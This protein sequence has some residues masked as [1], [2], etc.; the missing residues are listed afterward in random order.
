MLRRG[1]TTHYP[2]VHL[3]PSGYQDKRY[4]WVDT[5]SFVVMGSVGKNSAAVPDTSAAAD[6][7]IPLSGKRALLPEWSSKHQV[8]QEEVRA[9][10]TAHPGWRNTGLLTGDC[11][12]L[13]SDIMDP[14]AAE[15]LADTI[16][17]WFDGRG[18]ILTRF[19]EAPKF[20]TLFRTDTPFGKFRVDLVSP[21]GT[22]HHIEVLCDGQQ[23]VVDG[24]HPDTRKPYSWHGD[25]R[26]GTI[27]RSELPD[28]T[29]QELR[30]LVD[31]LVQILQEK[32][33]Y[34]R[35]Q[36]SGGGNG[37][38]PG[39]GSHS[40]VD[41]ERGLA[42]IRYGNI[43]DTWSRVVG[44][45]LRKGTPADTIFHR[46]LAATM[47]AAA[48][49]ADPK[50]DRWMAGLANIFTGYM[51]SD[52]S[53]VGNLSTKAQVRWHEQINNGERPKLAWRPDHGEFGQLY[54]RR[55]KG[56]DRK[57][58]EKQAGVKEE[59]PAGSSPKDGKAKP[60]CRFKL[61][62]FADL[63]LGSDPLYLVDELIPVRGLVDVWG[64]AKCGKSFWA[65]DLS[66]HI[67]MGWEY[68][69][70]YVQQ[71]AVVYCAFEGGHGFKKRKEALR[72]HYN[73]AED[74][75]VPLYL[76]PGQAN[77]I[78]EHAQLIA[79]ISM[80]LGEVR[81]VAVVLDTLNKSLFGSENKDID[82]GAYIRAAEAIRDAYDSVAL[83]I[84]H[85]GHDDTRPRGHSSLPGAVDAQLAV[86]RTENIVTV[87]VEMMRDGPE[88]TQVVNELIPVEVGMD[89]NGKT[90]TSLVV[91]PSSAEGSEAGRRHWSR[92]LN[93]FYA[94]AK[95]ALGA[96]GEL[97]QPEP[98]T[99]PVR[100]VNQEFIRDRF[101]ATYATGE[102]AGTKRQNK[103][104][105]AFNRAL[106]EA[107]DNGLIRSM[108]EPGTKA[109]MLWLLGHGN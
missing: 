42:G 19:G 82:M 85:C 31:L 13:D 16:R 90:L 46:V 95:S 67:A 87:T 17:D 38:D 30:S 7:P 10:A 36:A 2:V 88:E 65:F 56:P 27:S 20:A 5:P 80:Q 49:Q 6:T 108:H 62:P 75:H 92:S 51:H 15:I 24:I 41:S 89:R 59:A 40:L 11:P 76:M 60:N 3:R 91:V 54:V 106:A 107:Q 71:G 43:N 44:S 100:A 26:P 39:A 72:R 70:R 78:A 53:F 101:Y 79:S 23:L 77:L 25:R 32:F 93:I 69:D 1:D 68:R 64:R 50:R 57:P 33:D 105:Q 18:V 96:H 97:F 48:C 55:T 47:A 102:E 84:H 52:P 74:A 61:V 14:E 104:R 58:K 86:T 28:T 9:W 22:A 99:L 109:A 29:E 12:A 66:F 73:I 83:I 34:K 8:P 81:P 103:L 94:A 4:G 63:H 21:N 45:E 35:V 37:Y 98:G